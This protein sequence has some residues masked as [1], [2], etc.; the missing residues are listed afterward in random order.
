LASKGGL[1]FTSKLNASGKYE[2]LV[3]LKVNVNGSAITNGIVMVTPE[4]F[5]NGDTLTTT[6]G[7][8][9]DVKFFN[10]TGDLVANGTTG[11]Y[12]RNNTSLMFAQI[13]FTTTNEVKSTPLYV[14]ANANGMISNLV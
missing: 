14:V 12:D 2:T 1:T 10:A 7:T 9:T 4:K 6:L 5:V 11:A 8:T 13:K 3:N